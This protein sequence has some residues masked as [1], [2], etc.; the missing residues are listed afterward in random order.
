VCVYIYI[1]IYIK[2]RI[3]LNI[4]TI[5]QNNRK[6]GGA[7]HLIMWRCFKLR[8]YSHSSKRGRRCSQHCNNWLMKNGLIS[9]SSSFFIFVD[10]HFPTILTSISWFFFFLSSL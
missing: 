9:P 2:T 5:K 8:F 10:L 6:V 7:K 3:K 1:Y 4:L